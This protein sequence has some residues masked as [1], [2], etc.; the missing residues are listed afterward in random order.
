MGVPQI[1]LIV[2]LAIGC[3]SSLAKHGE[4]QE[5]ENCWYTIISTAI[6]VGLLSWGG[7]FG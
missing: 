2:L 3:G 1:I 6:L 5:D 4:P 7:F